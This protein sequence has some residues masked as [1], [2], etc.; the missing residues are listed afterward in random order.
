MKPE[1][2]PMISDA[3]MKGL[4]QIMDRCSG[5]NG[6]GVME[7]ALMAGSTLVEG[8]LFISGLETFQD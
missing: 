8:S 6:G 1:D 3:I 4:L 7:D 2:A 5:P